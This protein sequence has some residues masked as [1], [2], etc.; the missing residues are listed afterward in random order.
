MKYDT[1]EKVIHLKISLYDNLIWLYNVSAMYFLKCISLALNV[2]CILEEKGI[3][4]KLQNS[5]IKMA[6]F[7]VV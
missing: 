3:S 2:K 5:S 1:T 4:S 7:T 6:K